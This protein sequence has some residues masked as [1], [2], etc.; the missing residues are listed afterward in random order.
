MVP[1][2]MP[3]SITTR[4]QLRDALQPGRLIIMRRHSRTKYMDVERRGGRTL[5]VLTIVALCF[6]AAER[7]TAGQVSTTAWFQAT[8]QSL[9]DAVA[10]GDSTV[11]NRVMDER[12]IVT[13]EEGQVQTKAAFLNELHPLPR[14]LTGAIVV[15]D[16]TVDEFPGFAIVRYLADEWETVFAQRLTTKYRVTDTFRRDESSW[17]MIAS[18]VSVVTSDPPAQAVATDG[19][20]GLVGTYRLLPDGWTFHVALRD[21]RLFGGTDPAMLKPL[22]PLTPTAFVREGA[23]GEWLFVVGAG[24][25]ATHI[26]D[27][28]K[29]E[30]LVWTRVA[31]SAP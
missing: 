26:V 19:W 27:F 31:A 23:L 22:I 15:K 12:C 13:T 17:K 8:E 16:L 9:M 25:Q 10:A 2:S 18:H 30:P 29:F 28:R 4:H 5:A 24:G 21:G 11:W 7:R 14:G 20:P 3:Q 1:I 6:I